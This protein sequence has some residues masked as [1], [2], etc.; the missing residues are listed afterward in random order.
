MAILKGI[1]LVEFLKVENTIRYN[2]KTKIYKEDDIYVRSRNI[3][4]CR[5]CTVKYN[6]RDFYTA[7]VEERRKEKL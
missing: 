3:Y 4:Y 1:L 6:I 2:N 7:T 5:N